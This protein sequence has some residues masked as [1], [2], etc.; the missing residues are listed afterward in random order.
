M[1]EK[2]CG[3]TYESQIQLDQFL[4]DEITERY[5]PE[6][7]QEYETLVM[8]SFCTEPDVSS[9]HNDIHDEFL[10]LRNDS[11]TCDIF[12]DSVLVRYVSVIHKRQH[13]SMSFFHL[14]LPT[15]VKQDFSLLSVEKQGI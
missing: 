1:F 7:P 4:K 14:I 3:V 8:N 12:R 11:S 5:L 13:D 6:L 10:D 2:L 9:I 15:C